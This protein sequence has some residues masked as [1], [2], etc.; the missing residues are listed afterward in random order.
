M[1]IGND[2]P[3]ERAPLRRR[4]HVE[5][6]P[7]AWPRPGM[8]PVNKLVCAAILAAVALAILE[9][10]PA[11]LEL[12]PQRMFLVAELAFAALFLVEYTLRVY[13][14]GEDPRYRGVAGGCATW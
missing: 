7:D 13:A 3:G 6:V 5:L 14:A 2:M 8:L 1:T 9:T 11:V 4:L 12:V 10:E